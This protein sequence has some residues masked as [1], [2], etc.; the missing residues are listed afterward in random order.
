MRNVVASVSKMTL[1]ACETRT[2]RVV[3]GL[4]SVLV[5][6]SFGCGDGSGVGA[7][8]QELTAEE[9][10]AACRAYCGSEEPNGPTCLAGDDQARC[11]ESCVEIYEFG[12]QPSCDN[13]RRCNESVQSWCAAE[14][15]WFYRGCDLSFGCNGGVEKCGDSWEPLAQCEEAF[16]SDTFDW[17]A[18]NCPDDVVPAVS[19]CGAN[20]GSRNH[21]GNSCPLP[22][23]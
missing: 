20:T 3:L 8:P 10:D 15:F 16:R 5:M 14:R 7:G 1:V 22:V 21:W 19:V 6:S 23:E 12:T 2:N 18:A 4:A 13:G 9:L 17:C 11:L